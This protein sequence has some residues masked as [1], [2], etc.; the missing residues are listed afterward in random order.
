MLYEV[1]TGAIAHIGVAL[2][3]LGFVSSAKYDDKQTVTLEKG[4]AVPVLDGYTLTYLGSKSLTDERLG[5]EVRLRHD[6]REYS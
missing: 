3:F 6:T 4:R 2:L 5:F 1:I